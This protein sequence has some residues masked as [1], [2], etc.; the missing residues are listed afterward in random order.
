VIDDLIKSAVDPIVPCFPDVYEGSE[1]TYSTYNYNE[2]PVSHGDNAP[3]AVRYLIQV[4][5]FAP[6]GTNAATLRRRIKNALLGIGCTYPTATNM[7]DADGQH[8]ILE[9]DYVDGDV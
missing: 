4:H 2:L 9:C 7:S 8:W 6:T 5:L 3:E 1:L